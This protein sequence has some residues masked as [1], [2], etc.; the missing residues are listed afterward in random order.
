[1]AVSQ[2]NKALA[3]EFVT[4]NQA[5]SEWFGDNHSSV[6]FGDSNQ[7]RGWGGTDVSDVIT[8]DDMLVTEMNELID[9]CNIGVNICS[10]VSGSL[11]Y[12]TVGS[13]ILATDYNTIETKSSSI[14]AGRLAIDPTELSLSLGTS[15]QKTT[16]WGTT[17][18][19][20]FSLTFSTF[21]EARHFW[22]SGGA[23]VI[24]G[25]ISGYST[26]A[27][28][29]GA[30]IDDI[31]T[32]MGSVT[33]DYNSTAQSG[34][35]A[36]ITSLGYY[37]TTTGYQQVLQQNGT[38][39]YSNA[40]GR[41][42]IARNATGTIFYIQCSLTPEAGRTVDGTTQLNCYYRKLDNQSSGTAALTITAPAL[43]LVT[44]L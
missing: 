27:G 12:I 32:N 3:S 43:A 8:G 40:Y 31:L 7:D 21:A 34:S 11:S 24:N 29:D 6:T 19:A 22:N 18:S 25:S 26:G 44:P 20:V 39:A 35:G 33:V 37:D 38:G 28:Y 10:G 41:V 13:D 2:G 14:L 4:L 16:S 9:R 42:N 36:S 17:I 30:G 23:A 5:V 15:T 1:M